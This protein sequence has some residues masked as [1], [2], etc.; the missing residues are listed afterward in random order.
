M[1]RMVLVSCVET[2]V[3]V[4]ADYSVVCSTTPQKL[5]A[6]LPIRV[7]VENNQKVLVVHKTLSV[8]AIYA[9]RTSVRI[10]P[11]RLASPVMIM[12]IPIVQMALVADPRFLKAILFV[13]RLMKWLVMALRISASSQRTLP[14][15]P[16]F[17]APQAS[18]A[19]HCAQ[20]T[21]VLPVSVAVARK[22]LGRYASEP[23]NVK[24]AMLAKADSA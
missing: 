1:L 5:V 6:P 21:F 9:L 2:T 24:V 16:N 15:R 17:A 3:I 8:P 13:V 14:A 19:M 4:L 23:I 18:F 11:T 10:P 12:T 20:A 22:V 7:F